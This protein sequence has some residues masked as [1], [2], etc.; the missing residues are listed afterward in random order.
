MAGEE[1]GSVG[2]RVFHGKPLGERSV[3]RIQTGQGAGLHQAI[4]FL[5][6]RVDI[7]VASQL[8]TE[9]RDQVFF[10][11]TM[12]S[13]DAHGL[14]AVS[15]G[16]QRMGN[17]LKENQDDKQTKSSRAHAQHFRRTAPH[18]GKNKADPSSA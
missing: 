18:G 13:D 1:I 10:L 9:R 11:K 4:A 3:F 7:D 14:K 16:E 12:G 8:Q 2:H 15:L 5:L 17:C 6:Q